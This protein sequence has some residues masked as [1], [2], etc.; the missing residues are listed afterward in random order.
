M[1]E[2]WDGHVSPIL[3]GS[4]LQLIRLFFSAIDVP[5]RIW[6][7]REID[8]SK[9]LI[10]RIKFLRP[11]ADIRAMKGKSCIARTNWYSWSSSLRVV[12][13]SWKRSRDLQSGRQDDG[14]EGDTA[15]KSENHQVLHKASITGPIGLPVLGVHRT[16]IRPGAIFEEA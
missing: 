3:T 15:K 10:Q 8:R 4:Q 16:I 13:G 9:W 14:G 12:L 11:Y 1:C 7:F 5:S 6:C 2:C